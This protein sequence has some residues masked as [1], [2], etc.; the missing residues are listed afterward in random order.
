VC[1]LRKGIDY[2]ACTFSTRKQQEPA[3]TDAS[4]TS[5]A[6]S[7]IIEVWQHV[8]SLVSMPTERSNQIALYDATVLQRLRCMSVTTLR[9]LSLL[10]IRRIHEKCCSDTSV[11]ARN[12]LLSLYNS[13]QLLVVLV[14]DSTETEKTLAI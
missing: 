11:Y 2:S 3:A 12:C 13:Q 14:P 7:M 5:S 1:V 8:C 9:A 6:D 10:H 4:A